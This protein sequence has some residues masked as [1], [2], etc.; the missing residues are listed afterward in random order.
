MMVKGKDWE[1]VVRSIGRAE[2]RR[3]RSMAR[4]ARRRENEG[5]WRA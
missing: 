4:M 5:G 3:A 1:E 2:A